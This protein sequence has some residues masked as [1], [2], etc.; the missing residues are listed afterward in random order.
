MRIEPNK[1]VS[2]D[3]TL[4][5]DSGEVV[6]KSEKGEPLAFIYGSGSIIGGLERAL[7]GLE[8]GAARKVTVEPEEGYGPVRPE[9]VQKLPRRHFPPE[10]AEGMTFEAEGGHGP[11]LLLV[12]EVDAE[13]VLV[14][15]NH[16]LAGK[17]LHFDVRVA[18]VRDATDE[19]L[20]ALTHGGCVGCE[21]H[22]G[23]HGGGCCC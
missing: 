1:Y 22:D 3:Y 20:E 12:K 15:L 19:E 17:R 23:G 6:D 4:T 5:L 2:L 16:P 10:V 14:D 21:G 18:D 9:L 13:G 7:L 8:A 11:V